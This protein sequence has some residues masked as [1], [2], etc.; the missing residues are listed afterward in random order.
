MRRIILV[1]GLLLALVACGGPGVKSRI[2]SKGP[3]ET[4]KLDPVK[5]AAMKE[6]DAALRAL[7]LGGEDALATARDR[8]E[9]AVKIDPTLWEAWH[10]LGVIAQQDGDDDAAVKAFG[11]ALDVNPAHTPSRLARAEAHRRAGRTKDARED[12]EASLREFTEDDPLRADAAARLASLLR[13]AEAYDDAVDVLRD[14]LRVSGPS[15]LIYTELGLI[16]LEQDRQDMA[17]LVIARAIELDAKDPA[18]YNA[19]ALLYMAQGKAQEAF[20]RFDYATSLDPKYLDAR[21]NKAAV[22]LDAGDYQRAKAELTIIIEQ[23]PDDLAAHVALGVAQRGLKD[24][25]GAKKT[26]DEVVE[27]AP[28]RSYARADALYNLMILKLLF[29]EDLPGAK[30]ELE[31]Y[32]QDAPTSHPRRQDAEEKR[33]ELGL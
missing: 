29:L 25:Q 4:P 2:G 20:D 32:M 28:R 16:Y 19:L 33:K 26:W 27:D 24:L 1:V 13:D 18:A 12:Y 21:F 7:R 8:F 11:K 9:A 3:R 22:L 23:A 30:A 6:F 5:P 10:D 15:S 14:T 31:R 17:K